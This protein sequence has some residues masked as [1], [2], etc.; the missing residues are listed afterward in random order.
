MTDC[1]SV[2]EVDLV[3]KEVELLP[4]SE[5][6]VSEVP[7]LPDTENRGPAAPMAS[8]KTEI[9]SKLATLEQGVQKTI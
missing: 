6:V 1:C 9:V 5:P 3:L 7:T 2:P 4:A 8:C